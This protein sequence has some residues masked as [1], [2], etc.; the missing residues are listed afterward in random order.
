MKNKR[1][2]KSMSKSTMGV[3]PLNPHYPTLFQKGKLLLRIKVQRKFN[4]NLIP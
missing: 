3:R 1:Q 4:V 2:A